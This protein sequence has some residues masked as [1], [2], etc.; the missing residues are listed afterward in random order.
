MAAPNSIDSVGAT[1][2]NDDVPRSTTPLVGRAAELATVLTAVERAAG[3]EASVVV[4]GGDAGV[5]KTRLLASCSTG[6]PAAVCCSL[7]G[8][9]VDLGDA[10]PPYLPFTEAFARLAADRAR[11]SPRVLRRA[12]PAIARLLPAPRPQRRGGTERPR[13]PRRAVRLRP[14]RARP[15]RRRAAGRCSSSSRTCTGPTRPPATC[16]ASCSPGCDD[17]ARRDHRQLPQRRPAPPPPAASARSPNG[18]GCRGRAGSHLDPLGADDVRDPRPGR[19]TRRRS[20]STTCAASSAVPTATPS[21]PRSWSPPPSSA[22]TPGSCRGSWP[23]CCWSA[24]TGSP[25]TPGEVVRVAAVAGRRVSHDMLDRRRRASPAPS[26]DDALRDA[27]DAHI[28][29]PTAERA[30]LH[31]PARPAGRGGL[32]RPAAGRAG[33]A[34]RGVRRRELA[35]HDRT[36]SAAELARHARASHD[37][38]TAYEASVEAGDEAMRRRRAAGGDAAL[39]DR[40]RTRRRACRTR[41]TTGTAGARRWSTRP[42]PPGVP[43]RPA[44]SRARHSPTLARTR[45]PMT[46]RPAAATPSPTPRWRGEI[47]RKPFAA[48]RRGAAPG[49]APS[50]PPRSARGSRRCTPAPRMILGREVDAER[51]ATEAVDIAAALGCRRVGGRRDHARRCSSAGAAEP[52]EVAPTAVRASR[53]RPAANGETAAE[54]RSSYNLGNLWLEHGDSPWREEA[55]DQATWRARGFGRPWAAFGMRGA[56]HGR[57]RAVPAR[58]LGRAHCAPWT[59]AVRGAARAGRGAASAPPRC[60]CAAGRGDA[61]ALELLPALRPWWDRDGRIA[62]FAVAA[63]LESTSSTAA[64]RR[65]ALHR[66]RGRAPDRRSGRSRGSSPGSRLSALGVAVL[67]AAAAAL[68][69]AARAHWC[70]ARRSSS[71]TAATERGE[72]PAAGR[73][74]GVEGAGLARPARGRVGTAA[75]DRGPGPAR[76][77]RTHRAAGERPSRHST[78]ATWSSWRRAQRPARRRPARGRPQRRGGRVRRPGP[79]PRPRAA[80]PNRCWPS[81]APLG[82]TG[83]PLRAAHR[84][85]GRAHRPRT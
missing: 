49:T 82:T 79:R 78:T 2:E 51:W 77:G 5:G 48:H 35:A 55:F 29:Q 81:C 70:S 30:R 50:R 26:L 28:L 31:V 36:A 65:D 74:L 39:R 33:P 61:A 8:H 40:P 12:C 67:A 56:G 47:D 3:G 53:T 19:C 13:R 37:L 85:T 72:G 68:R 24:S 76:R 17:A 15:A 7:V 64:R 80:A 63:A 59:S 38:P 10:P 34:A 66:R 20:P 9:C 42:S 44:G 45:H 60:W 46:P 83:P 14:R 58:R 75:L 27:V 21:S 18:R 57:A 16:S 6:A 73:R 22:P 41:R 52:A 62:L 71:P 1:R 54:L 84:L 43:P 4:L 23:T 69:S 25:T 11:P 32:R